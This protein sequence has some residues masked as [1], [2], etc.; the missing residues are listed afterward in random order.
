MKILLLCS[1]GMSTTLLVNAMQKEAKLQNLSCE[2]QAGSA[3]LVE[4]LAENFDLILVAPQIRHKLSTIKDAILSY[5]KPVELIPS[6][7]YGQIQ[8]AKAL[9]FAKDIL[10]SNETKKLSQKD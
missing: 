10:E 2:I 1:G 3:S 9:K 7:I 4:E 6:D 8:G 5:N